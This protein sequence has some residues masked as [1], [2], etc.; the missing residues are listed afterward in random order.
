MPSFAQREDSVPSPQI[1]STPKRFHRHLYA[2]PGLDQELRISGSWFVSCGC[3][4]Q[5]FEVLHNLGKPDSMV[6]F[7]LQ[8]SGT[9]FAQQC[10]AVLLILKHSYF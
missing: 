8:F 6:P 3:G 2:P 7:N 4:L 5:S 1:S 9:Y 10:E